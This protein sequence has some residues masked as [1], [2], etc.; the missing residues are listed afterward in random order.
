MPWD[1]KSANLEQFVPPWTVQ[2]K[3]WSDSLK[4][5]HSG[6]STGVLLF[7]DI[8]LSLI[9]HYRIHKCGLPHIAFRK[10][11]LARLRAL[12]SPAARPRGELLSPV[13]SGPV[14]MRHARSAELESESPR[15]TRHAKHRMW[16]VR[17]L[18]ESVGDLQILTIQEPSDLQGA[19][20]YECRPPLLPVS[21][22]LEDIGPLPMRQKVVSASLAAPPR[23]DCMAIGGVSPEGVAIPEL[24][25]APLVDPE[26]DLEDEL[27]A[28]ED[29][30]LVSDSRGGP[31]SGGSSRASGYRR[32]GVREGTAQCVYSA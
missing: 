17:V 6:I 16:P 23:E 12:L 28:P 14:S 18:D 13:S 20:V 15:R 25:V 11:Y 27:L 7:S 2:R 30:T 19:I 1:V 22:R 4:A 5:S 29:S 24:G 10:D 9:H 31:S 21:L 26:T 3:V 32:S 8:N